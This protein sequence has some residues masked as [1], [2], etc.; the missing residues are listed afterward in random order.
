MEDAAA[1]VGAVICPL[2][3]HAYD[4]GWKMQL[5]MWVPLSAL[6][7]VMPTVEEAAAQVGIAEWPNGRKG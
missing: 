2:L 5:H 4:G 7:L 3:S 1:H 6:C